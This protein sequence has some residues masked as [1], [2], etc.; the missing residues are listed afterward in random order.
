LST[1]QQ[2]IAGH[3][4]QCRNLIGLLSSN[5]NLAGVLAPHFTPSTTSPSADSIEAFL[6][7]YELITNL[8]KNECDLIFVL[9]T[10]FDLRW[11][12][13]CSQTQ[14]ADRSRLLSVIGAA[15]EKYGLEPKAKSLAVHEVLRR[16]WQQIFI[17]NFPEQYQTVLQLLIKSSESQS[18]SLVLWCDLI[19]TLG[20]GL[21][22]FR[23]DSNVQDFR[24]QVL[25]YTTQQTLLGIQQVRHN[26]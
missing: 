12:L 26:D 3:P 15:L 23:P 19:N 10:K 4:Q 9:L 25:Q 11:W 21:L 20:Q 22:R 13:K 24:P 16:H 6:D 18:C 7:C 5:A 1:G 8:S 17:D 14:P 2:C